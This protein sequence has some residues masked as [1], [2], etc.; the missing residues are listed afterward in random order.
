MVFLQTWPDGAKNTT[1]SANLTDSHHEIIA[2][3]PAFLAKQ[4]DAES[5]S[6]RGYANWDGQGV[7]NK[8]RL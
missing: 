7:P 6:P 8:V 5:G 4:D 3:F 1:T 2:N